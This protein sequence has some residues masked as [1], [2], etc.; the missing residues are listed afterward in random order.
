PRL[1]FPGS[2]PVVVG[3]GH[4]LRPGRGMLLGFVSVS[5]A[6]LLFYRPS[7]SGP[8]MLA[9]VFL[10]IR[11]RSAISVLDFCYL[12]L[13]FLLDFPIFHKYHL[14]WHKRSTTRYQ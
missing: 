2:L 4:S 14:S 6:S 5:P 8:T 11:R 9:I 1:M 7:E 12:V 13:I 10:A 3:Q